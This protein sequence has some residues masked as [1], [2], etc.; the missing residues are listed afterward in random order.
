MKIA[1]GN[2][3][4]GVEVKEKIK[5]HLTKKKR[6]TGTN[7]CNFDTPHKKRTHCYQQRV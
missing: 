3:H 7:S 5:D 1:I 4:A 2:D 6:Q